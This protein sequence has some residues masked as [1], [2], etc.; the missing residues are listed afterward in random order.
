MIG[1]ALTAFCEDDVSVQDSLRWLLLAGVV[2]ADLW[3]LE[4]WQLV[5]ARLVKV[6]RETGALSAL[7]LALDATAVVHVFAGELVAAAAVVEEV[8]TVSAAIG[9]NQPVFGALALAAISGHEREART[10]IEA[11]VREAGVYGLG[12]MVTSAHYHHAV[13]CN[14][15]SQYQE[16][17]TAARAAAT[18]QE[19]FGAPQWALAELVEAAARQRASE[20]A[21]EALEQLSGIA[22]VSGTEWALGVEARSRALV[23]DGPDAERLYREAIE[24]LSRT[25]VRIHLARAHLV[26]GEWLRRENRRVDARVQLGVAHEMLTQFGAQAFADRA[27][28]ELAAVGAKVRQGPVAT[29]VVLTPQEEQIARLAG[30]GLTNP[31]IGSRLFLSHHTVEWHLRKVFSKLG[32]ASRRE[33]SNALPQLTTLV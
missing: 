1:R 10:L 19:D 14:G 6:T 11:T 25:R 26:Y 2:A 24:R 15:L 33:I 22:Q 13:L 16:A 4:R 7:P 8:R 21:S 17:E 18:H 31:E 29:S 23:S 27:R 28:H 3:D 32:I 20:R 12:L 30:D 5:E 9:T